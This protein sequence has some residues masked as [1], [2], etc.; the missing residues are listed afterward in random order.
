MTEPKITERALPKFSIGRPVTVTMILLAVLVVGLI[1]YKRVKMDLLPAGVSF[2]F[3][4]VWVPYSDS[5]PKEL[6]E[7]IV[8]PMEGELKTV[9]NLKRLY[10][11]SSTQGSWFWMEFNQGTNMDLAYSQTADRVERVRPLLPSDQDY[12]YIR[13]FG[14]NQEPVLVM[15]ISYDETVEDPYYASDKFLR[16]AMEGIKGV[17]NVELFGIREKNIQIIVDTDK[18]RTYRVNLPVLMAALM[19]DNFAM[20]NGYVYMGKKKY[21]LRTKSRF[22][23]LDDIRKIE[24]GGGVRLENIAEVV[25]DFDE[26]LLN[27]MRV[28]GKL[29][30]GIA[31]FKES[32]ANTVDVCRRIEE[33]LE[34]QFKTRPELKGVDYFVFWDQGTMITES[35]ENVQTTMMWGGFFAFFVLLFFLRKIRITLMLTLAIPLSLLISVLLIYALGWTLNAFTMMGLMISIGLVVD[36]SIVITE[37]IYRFNGLGYDK[38]R[39][40]ILGASEVG[41]AIILAT[42]TTIVVFLP[43]MIMSGDSILSF[44]LTRIGVPVIFAILGSLFIALI[45]IPLASIKSLPPKAKIIQPT[46]NVVTQWYQD[47]LVK[48]LKH[49]LDAF[50]VILL[51]IISTAWPL[52]HMKRS[53]VAHGGPTDARV[54]CWFPPEYNAEK[55]DKALS[56]ITRKIMEKKDV[57]HID[58]TFS[59]AFDHFGRIEIYL[60][61]DRDT[62]WYQ[63]IY[64]KAVNGLGLSD[65]RRLSRDELTEDIKENLPVIPGVRLRTTWREEEGTE[66]SLTFLLRGYDIGVLEDLATELEKQLKLEEGVLSVETDSETGNDEIHVA[67]NREKA[68]NIG[69]NPNYIGQLVRFTLGRRRISNYQTPEREIGIF[70]KSRADQRQSVAQ[71]K[72]TFIKTDSGAETTLSAISDLTYHRSVGRIRRENGKSSLEMKVYFGD[73]DIKE[74][75][76]RLEKVFKNFKLP[77]GYSY[78][79]GGRIRRFQEQ[80]SDMILSLVFAFVLVFLIMGVL[81]ESFS[82]PLSV[83][84]AIP[85]AFVG[86]YW[87]LYITGTTFEI[88]AGIGLVVLIGVVVNNAIVLIDLINQYRNSGMNREQAILV[89]GMHRFRPILMTALTTIFGL[90][91]MAVGSTGLVG[92]P[93]APMG[94][95]LIGGLISSTFLTLF[96]VPVFYTYIDDLRGFFTKMM[97]RF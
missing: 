41:L 89:A 79:Q 74:M 68:F 96:A 44:Y 70:V 43:L 3:M 36:N 31:L 92:I 10:S 20:S 93:Y 67:A 2:P 97:K 77:T 46:H 76:A 15:G 37:N 62:Q 87:L 17:A 12:I 72:N 91:P 64:R 5:N 55:V 88:M 47:L 60:E 78:E 69:T 83:L 1:S 71:L 18:V 90:L 24:I 7:Q 50:I 6:E 80:D 94:I 85:A 28:D 57:Y 84:I 26:E 58:H 95:T 30:A 49:R 52:N 39:S 14:E 27:I 42:L 61:P 75:T 63:A 22:Y 59:R 86:S 34:E 32:E 38:T 21:L 16:Q 40:A 51:I 4:A 13:R 45:L 23:S 35:I 56:Y 33:K 82:L 25:Y 66:T 54:L 81:F 65:Y 19:R 8:R 11:S 9:K 73:R 48:I 29:A 53:D